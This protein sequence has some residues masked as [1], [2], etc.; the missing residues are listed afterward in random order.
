MRAMESTKA[1]TMNQA[2]ALVTNTL[3]THRLLHITALPQ[4]LVGTA[5]NATS[6]TATTA[7]GQRVMGRPSARTV[8]I[9]YAA[10]VAV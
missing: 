6:K 2:M 4:L 7:L 3:P 9:T 8:P 5:V 10:N 1:P